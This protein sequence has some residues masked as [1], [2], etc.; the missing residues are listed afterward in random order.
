MKRMVLILFL[1]LTTCTPE[2]PCEPRVTEPQAWSESE[3]SLVG[4]I[5]DYRAELGLNVVITNEDLKIESDK[6]AEVLYYL[7]AVTHDGVGAAFIALGNK[8]YQGYAEILGGGYTTIESVLAA[9][10]ES[11]E[12]NRALLRASSYYIGVANTV[13]ENGQTIYV[14]LL[15]RD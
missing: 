13:G 7:P 5:N 14:I 9:W 12:H 4:L 3:L 8:C 6:R 2:L 10:K 15:A 1:L 11:S